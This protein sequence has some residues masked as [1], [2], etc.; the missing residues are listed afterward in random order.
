MIE[1]FS[2]HGVEICH[3]STPFDG[4]KCSFNLRYH[5]DWF[6]QGVMSPIVMGFI[7]Q[8]QISDIKTSASEKMI[9]KL[10]SDQG[11]LHVYN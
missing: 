5:S 11:I 6:S 3:M 2:G 1:Y 10:Y 8:S 9:H 4:I 7:Q